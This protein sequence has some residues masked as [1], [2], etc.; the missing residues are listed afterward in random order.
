MGK[1]AEVSARFADGEDA[2]RLQYEPP[3]LTF[4]GRERRVFEGDALKSV[5]ADGEDLVL[6]DGARFRLGEK[7]ARSWAEAIANPKGRLDKLGVKPG[8]KV[9]ILNLDDAAFV[10]ELDGAGVSLTDEPACL[11]L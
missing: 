6:A 5:R 2:G 11:D 8:L 9:A 7:A 3:K 1:E 4:R 10:A